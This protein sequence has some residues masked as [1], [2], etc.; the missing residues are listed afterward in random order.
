[1]WVYLRLG[2]EFLAKIN[3]LL[4]E[5]AAVWSKEYVAESR[6]EM[7]QVELGL[8]HLFARSSSPDPIAAWYPITPLS[9][10]AKLRSCC[11]NPT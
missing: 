4:V 9:D 5:I 10:C 2:F 7:L 3:K 1:M 8:H 6:I 11:Q